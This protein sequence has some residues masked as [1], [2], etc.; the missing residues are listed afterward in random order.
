MQ[1]VDHRLL[2]QEPEPEPEQPQQPPSP[3]AP[4]P[5][6]SALPDLIM[7]PYVHDA[8]AGRVVLAQHTVDAVLVYAAFDPSIVQYATQH[9][10][11]KGAE[12]CHASLPV[13]W[14]PDR[15]SWIKTNFLLRS[16][17]IRLPA[18]L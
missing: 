9:Q 12:Q 10:S 18:Y 7:T 4:Q 11:F 17:A 14:A 1:Y 5:I 3:R 16:Q 2:H 15:M 8:T 13:A 6:A